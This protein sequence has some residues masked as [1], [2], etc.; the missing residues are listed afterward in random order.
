[1]KTAIITAS[2]SLALAGTAAAQPGMTSQV[3]G[4]P[5]ARAAEPL[6]ENL[7]LTLSLGGTLGSLGLMFGAASVGNGSESMAALM[8]TAGA[9][10]FVF[11]PS[12]GHWYARK[13]FT[14]GLGCRLVGGAALFGAVAL[15]LENFGSSDDG[16]GESAVVGLVFSGLILYVVGTL[17]DIVTA[18]SRVRKHNQRLK[19]IAVTPLAV[20][21]GGGLGLTGRF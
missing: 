3:P 17:D 19:D 11:G 4:E 15:A 21:H 20:S 7:A 18:P 5:A 2:L 6:S 14:R 16:P 12:F 13:Y 8:G 9:L 10:G 1:M